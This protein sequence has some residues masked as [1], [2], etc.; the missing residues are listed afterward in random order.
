MSIADSAVSAATVY[1]LYLMGAVPFAVWAGRTAH[2]SALARKA[3]GGAARPGQT[4]TVFLVVLPLVLM[5][6]CGWNSLE[7]PA[8]TND[9]LAEGPGDWQQVGFLAISPCAG[10]VAGYAIGWLLA[11]REG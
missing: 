7:A 9:P 8:L 3:A 1:L 6:W 2:A 4:A 5:A 10:L 11:R